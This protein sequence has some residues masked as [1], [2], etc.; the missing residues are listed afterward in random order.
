MDKHL[1]LPILFLLTALWGAGI[2]VSYWKGNLSVVRSFF[3]MPVLNSAG[4]VAAS[5]LIMKAA[6]KADH[7]PK[8]A[9]SAVYR[10]FCFWGKNSEIALCIHLIELRTFPWR[11]LQHGPVFTIIILILKICLISVI[12]YAIQR[13]ERL[14]RLF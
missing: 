2:A 12:V 14:K 8:M 3:P 4:A 5:Y 9:N 13:N 7:I 1:T 10:F 6:Q 11:Y